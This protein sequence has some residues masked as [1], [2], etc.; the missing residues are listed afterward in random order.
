MPGQCH[1][2]GPYN[3]AGI[4]SALFVIWI[5]PGSYS[6]HVSLSCYTVRERNVEQNLAN[7][8]RVGP[9]LIHRLC[10]LSRDGKHDTCCFNAGPNV[11][12]KLFQR[13]RRW[14]NIK[15]TLGQRL[16]TGR[17]PVVLIEQEPGILV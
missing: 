11:V 3:R 16:F 9:T 12:L 13:L 4:G 17:S 8:A 6:C 7:V 10:L 15:A 1:I 5:K 2:G 14:P